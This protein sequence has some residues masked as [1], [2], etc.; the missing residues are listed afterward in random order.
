LFAGDKACLARIRQR[1]KTTLAENTYAH[2]R[3]RKK[4]F[5]FC[6]NHEVTENTAMIC[7][8]LATTKAQPPLK[9]WLNVLV[10]TGSFHTFL[11]FS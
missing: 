5:L 3:S 1:F 2:L 9:E 8:L 7:L 11:T 4:N 6:G 10:I